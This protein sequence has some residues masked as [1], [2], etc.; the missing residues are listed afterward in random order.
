MKPKQV[1][2]SIEQLRIYKNIDKNG[3]ECL[4]V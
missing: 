2:T 1:I 4:Y 3:D